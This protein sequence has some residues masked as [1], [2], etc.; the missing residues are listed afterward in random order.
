MAANNSWAQRERTDFY[1]DRSRNARFTFYQYAVAY[2]QVQMWY[3][4]QNKKDEIGI[5]DNLYSLIKY[6]NPTITLISQSLSDN[7][8]INHINY[9]SDY[10]YFSSLINRIDGNFIETKTN[11]TYNQLSDILIDPFRKPDNERVY[12]LEDST[13]WRIYRGYGGALTNELAYLITPSEWSIGT[14]SDLIDEGIGVLTI[15]VNYTSTSEVVESGIKYQAGDQ[16]NA[17]SADLTSGQVISSSVLVDS[18]LPP[19]VFE[20][21]AA[22]VAYFLL[23]SVKDAFAT[24]FTAT[25]IAQEGK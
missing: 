16:F 25:L 18:N 6:V 9:P 12:T 8:T 2:R 20:E 10:H 21:V 13:G 24:N 7:L 23:G 22:R 4:D 14:E 1:I 5:R 15:G 11:L 17:G 3:F 19:T